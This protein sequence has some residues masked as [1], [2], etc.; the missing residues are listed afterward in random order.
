MD[1]RITTELATW[2]GAPDELQV[3]RAVELGG[4]LISHNHRQRR[5]F[6]TFVEAERAGRGPQRRA[7]AAASSVLL[8]PRD[9]SNARL[10]LR[11]TLLLD[12]YLTQPLLKPPT[13]L[14]NAVQRALIG[15][16]RP[17]GYTAAD[18]RVALGE[19]PSA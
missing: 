1:V 12:W 15:G 19:A 8:L 6:G 17:P 2:R 5:Q 3:S 4:V 18:V 14:W 7:G 16:W 11:T 9:T 10:L 13:L